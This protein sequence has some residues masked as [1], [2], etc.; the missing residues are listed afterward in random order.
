MLHI[1]RKE[2]GERLQDRLDEPKSRWKFNPG[3]L[4]DRKLWDKYQAA[5]EIMLD[6]G[7]P[8]RTRRGM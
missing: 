4:E 5:Y 3:D 8:P 2:Q 7:A 1:S 6:R